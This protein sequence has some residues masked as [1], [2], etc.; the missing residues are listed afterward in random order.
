[1]SERR[2]VPSRVACATLVLLASSAHA[3]VTVLRT[4]RLFDP[5]KGSV[6]VDQVIV[7]EDGKIKAVGAGLPAPAGATL[8]DL[9]DAT[10]L[11]GLFD[12]H[13]HLCSSVAFHGHG[14]EAVMS[15]LLA[16]TTQ[17]TDETP[18]PPS[19]SPA[20]TGRCSAAGSS[21]SR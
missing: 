12:C 11:P 16:Y 13:T 18:R 1:M 4:G 19:R 2:S 7:V 3:E 14:F 9:K 6:A 10:V 21:A 8:V 20:C 5:E 17:T 15:E